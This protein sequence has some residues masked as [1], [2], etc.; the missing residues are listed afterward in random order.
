VFV[1][2]L[3]KENELDKIAKLAYFHEFGHILGVSKKSEKPEDKKIFL[4][5][6]MARLNVLSNPLELVTINNLVQ[7]LQNNVAN[8]DCEKINEQLIKKFMP[9]LLVF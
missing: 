6:F 3:A 8:I 1:Y 4:E 5:E 2:E 7:T 9:M